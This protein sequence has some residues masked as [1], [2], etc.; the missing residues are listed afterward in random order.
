VTAAQQIDIEVLADPESCQRTA[1][2][3]ARLGQAC[4]LV[5]ARLERRAQVSEDDLGGLS[6]VAY[7]ESVAGTAATCERLAVDCGR[8]ADGLADYARDIADVRRLMG[9]ARATAAPWLTTCAWAIW[10]PGQPPDP[11]D[12]ALSQRWDAWHDAVGWWR[13]ARDLEDLAE[14]RW[15]HVLGRAAAPD[16]P[17]PAEPALPG[18]DHHQQHHKSDHQP[19]APGTDPPVGPIDTDDPPGPVLV[20]VAGDGPPPHHHH[21]TG[22]ERVPEPHADHKTG[23]AM[24]EPVPVNLPM[25]LPESWAVSTGLGSAGLLGGAGGRDPITGPDPTDPGPRDVEEAVR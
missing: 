23:E 8:L 3:L 20:T 17:D 4:V 2:Q 22:A 10:S 19:P 21:E 12:A 7:R 11:A 14:Q 16:V 18:P 5:G 1:A 6:G 9:R 24:A 25:N 15:L 13:Q